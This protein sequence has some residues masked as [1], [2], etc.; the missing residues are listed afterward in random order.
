MPLDI[1]HQPEREMTT[2]V[3]KGDPSVADILR[4][5]REAK[6]SY[7]LTKHTIWDGRDAFFAHFERHDLAMLDHFLV[8]IQNHCSQRVGGRSALLTGNPQ[9][10]WLL[11]DFAK[12]NYRLP[13]RRQVV[14][15]M[16]AA[17]AWTEKGILPRNH[18]NYPW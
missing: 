5:Y 8:L 18:G 2:F 12:L 1:I 10:A 14:L 4:A 13:Q 6:E 9:D 16:E 15:S 7:G 11:W 17:L 3:V